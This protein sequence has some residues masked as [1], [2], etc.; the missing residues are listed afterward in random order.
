MKAPSILL[1][2]SILVAFGFGGISAQ[3]GARDRRIISFARSLDVAR[4]DHRLP[5]QSF[6]KWLR[7][8]VGADA[9]IEWDVDDCG[10]QDG[11]PSNPTNRNPPLCANARTKMAD[12]EEMGIAI[13]VGSH[14]R[15]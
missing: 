2:S 14:K 3:P 9:R 12:G 5:H 6:D 7:S 4:L 1:F 10:E 13:A 11:N 15:G 8:V